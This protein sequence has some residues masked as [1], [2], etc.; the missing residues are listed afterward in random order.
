[1]NSHGGTRKGAGRPAGA[2]NVRSLALVERLQELFPDWCPLEQLALAAQ[3]ETLDVHT[4]LACAEKVAAYIYPK[5]KASD[6]EET[7][8][9][10]DAAAW[11]DML[12]EKI[13][14]EELARASIPA[15]PLTISAFP[16]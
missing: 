1:M 8:K 3:D 9:R 6:A 2:R 5:P 15:H 11:I 10:A 16:N 14:E 12:A 4:R 13:R 7:K